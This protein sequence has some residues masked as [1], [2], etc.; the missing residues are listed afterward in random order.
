MN[1][2][3]LI[4]NLLYV[5]GNTSFYGK[6][7]IGIQNPTNTLDVLGKIKATEIEAVGSNITNINTSNITTGVLP[8]ARG[9]TGID[10]IN[11]SQ[12]L[13]GGAINFEQKY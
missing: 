9:G 5:Y 10:A 11:F 2:E 3:K 6:I 7:G 8:V 12:I 4:A 1:Q 13:F